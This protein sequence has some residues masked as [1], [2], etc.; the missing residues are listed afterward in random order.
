[1]L[2]DFQTSFTDRLSIKF[3]VNLIK[4][5]ITSQT[6][7]YTTLW[8]IN[9]GKTATTWSVLSLTI[10]DNVGYSNVISAWGTFDHYFT[11]D[12]LPILFERIFIESIN[13]W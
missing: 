3:L 10:H 1:M 6:R 12:L 2:T 11:T 7:R 13:I 4:Y 5:P 8:N 9:V